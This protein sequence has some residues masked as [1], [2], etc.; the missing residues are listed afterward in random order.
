MGLNQNLCKKVHNIDSIIR[1]Q[2][3]AWAISAYSCDERRKAGQTSCLEN[4]FKLLDWFDGG[5]GKNM[6]GERNQGGWDLRFADII[7]F[8]ETV[9]ELQDMMKELHLTSI[10]IDLCMNTLKT[11]IIC[12]DHTV[13]SIMVDG[14]MI[15]QVDEYVY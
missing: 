15:N 14:K 12:K 8:A 3:A 2:E 7:I 6:N 11:R 4:I 1:I 5:K 10:H 13:D 9:D